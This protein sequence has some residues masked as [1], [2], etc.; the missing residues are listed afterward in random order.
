M[1]GFKIK[2]ARWGLQTRLLLP[3]C[4]VL[5]AALGQSVLSNISTQRQIEDAIEQRGITMLNEITKSLQQQQQSQQGLAQLLA[6]HSQLSTAVAAKD[7]VTLEQILKPLQTK[8]HLGNIHIY[9]SKEREIIHLG[10][11]VEHS[12]AKQLL[13]SAF[14]GLYNSK[15]EIHKQGLFVLASAPIKEKQGMVGV[16]LI[17]RT[18]TNQELPKIE[19]H[20]DAELA[21]FYQGKLSVTTIKNSELLGLLHKYTLNANTLPLLKRDLV[22]YNWHLTAKTLPNNGLSIALVSTKDLVKASQQ[23]H[24]ILLIGSLIMLITLLCFVVVLSQDITKP[25]KIMVAAT[26]DIVRG[27]YHRRVLPCKIPELNDLAKAI[28][29][30]AQQLEIQ[31]AELS[32]Q[33]FHDSLTNL[34][35]RALFL[36]RLDRVL[37]DIGTQESSV[38]VLFLDLDGFKVINDS[39]G[40][41]AGDQLLIAVSKRLQNCLRTEDIVARL[42]GDEFTILLQNLCHQKDGIIVAERIIEQLQTPFYLGGREIFISSSIG[43]ALNTTGYERSDDLMRNA[44]AAM[45]EAKKRGKSRY[46]IF[47]PDMDSR[48]FERLQLS[49]DLRRAIE[50]QEFR[51]YYQP[52]VQL[53]SGKII[54][55]EAL[56]RWQ[57]P[58]IGLISPVKFVP[59]AEETGLILPIG[60]WVLRTACEQAQI[61]HLQ[62]PTDPPL[63]VGVNLSPKQ[64][65]QPQLVDTIACILAETGLNPHHLKLEI[66]ESMMMEQGDATIA[67]LYRLKNLGIR[68]AIDDFGTGFSALSYLKRFPVDTL[69]IDGSFIKGLG[70]NREDTAIVHAVIAFAKAL[71]L[72][73]TAEGVETAEQLAQLQV[74]GCDR[75]QGYYFSEAVS[76]DI[77]TYLIDT[78]L[79]RLPYPEGNPSQGILHD[80]WA[81]AL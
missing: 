26:G 37:S 74:L 56:V 12:I 1:L 2:L 66:T 20:D 44:D 39:L 15:V 23:R 19:K 49:T 18:I 52:V 72:S 24:R 11:T 4:L 30:L 59:L 42:G 7:I 63:V 76:T 40:H 21:L 64:F 75:G 29:Y 77:F 35:N 45:Y 60:E 53:E 79:D 81:T 13:K 10:Q 80:G 73:V 65:Q 46:T 50:R 57:H 3:I 22:K 25:L 58:R 55:V 9:A 54:E 34:P 51:L 68:L 38:A 78:H 33:A 16:I 61:W 70:H 5:A 6:E 28:N 31:L 17:S 14:S 62:H 36:E 69:K 32:R 8:L 67:T 43:I 47:N 41:K 27:N 48:A 71:H